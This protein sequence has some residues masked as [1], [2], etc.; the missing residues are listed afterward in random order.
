MSRNHD[1]QC[2]GLLLPSRYFI[3]HVV[4]AW[5]LA[6]SSVLAEDK[7]TTNAQK[8]YSSSGLQELIVQIPSSTASSFEA[9]LTKDTLP[10]RFSEVEPD[11]IKSAVRKAFTTDTFDKHMTREI[12]RTMSAESIE[13]MLNWYLSPLGNRI[14][15]AEIDNSLL[16][17]QTR[18]EAFQHQLTNSGADSQREQLIFKLDEVMHSTESAV[19]MMA[20]I[21]VA[22]NLS[23]SRFLPEEQRLSSADIQAL[24]KRNH[25]QLTTQYRNQTREV[26][27]FTYQDFNNDELQEFYAALKTVAG[28]EFVASINDGIKKGMF[29]SSLDLGDELG[30]LIA[31][32]ASGPGI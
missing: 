9:T 20:S 23:L 8:L 28:Q 32:D 26:L 1:C 27:L 22:F 21:Q 2:F 14:K 15:R 3:L 7:S 6:V 17:E 25:A 12:D 5:C 4:L 11:S 19:D 29:A 31:E 24:A 18:F 13:A 10:E 30:A 16:T